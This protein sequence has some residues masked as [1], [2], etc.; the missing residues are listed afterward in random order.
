MII[1]SRSGSGISDSDFGVS[2]AT[3]SGGLKAAGRMP[4]RSNQSCA[5]RAISCPAISLLD[6]KPDGILVHQGW[7]DC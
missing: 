2:T 6:L 3:G 1:R 5:R 7:R 4:L